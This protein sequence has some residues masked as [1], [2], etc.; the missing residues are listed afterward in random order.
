MKRKIALLLS[1]IM[2]LTAITA[3]GADNSA[4]ANGTGDNAPNQN[5]GVSEVQDSGKPEPRVID[6]DPPISFYQD[7]YATVE[8]VDFHEEENWDQMAKCLTLKVTNNCDREVSASISDAYLGDEN[9]Q[10]SFWNGGGPVLPG[11]SKTTVFH[12]MH[13]TQP[14]NTEL[15]S[16]EDVAQ[17]D[18]KLEVNVFSEDGDSIV[19]STESLFDLSSVD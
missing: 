2:I 19:H 9:V 1:A 12:F 7:E 3:C 6:L 8:V 18:G 13:V 17:L 15:E 10:V 14:D 16:L 11:K 5:T 4:A